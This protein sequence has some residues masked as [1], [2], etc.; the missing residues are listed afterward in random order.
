M[1]DPLVDYLR[2]CC[3][4]VLG[5]SP[6]CGFFVAPRLVVTCSHVV[7]R[8]VKNG[9]EIK[10]EQWQ[11]GVI[12][13]LAGA[14]VLA[15]F[16]NEDI[17]LIET[18]EPSL[19]FAPLS[20]EVQVGNDLTALGFP[21][22]GNRQ[23]FDQFTVVY[24]GQ[25]SFVDSQGGVGAEVKYKAGQVE[26][27]FSGGP[28]L[29]LKSCRVMGVVNVT[30]S[31]HTDL[32]GWAIA[33]SVVERLLQECSQELPSVAPGWTTA[34]TKQRAGLSPETIQLTLD[35][36]RQ[37]MLNP[38]R[39]QRVEQLSQSLGANQ[40]AIRLALRSLG[41]REQQIADEHL[42]LKLIESIQAYETQLQ[43]LAL[44]RSEDPEIEHKF[45][46]ARLALQSDNPE[47]ADTSLEDA[48]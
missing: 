18:V 4:H 40:N 37:M 1:S 8:D 25:T 21:K 15:N 22:R 3:V 36:L 16:P 35:Q 26:P 41:A 34:E 9:A 27:G 30:R 11:L 44:L 39:E 48:A 2:L 24:E 29:N 6:G 20:S 46:Q 31:K 23:E 17:A 5:R 43:S 13:P 10:L 47:E 38:E 19:G 42:A 28:L 14:I 32:G 45:E 7:G 33:V 12:K